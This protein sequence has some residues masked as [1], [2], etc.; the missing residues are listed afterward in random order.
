[1]FLS[2]FGLWAI[3][4]ISLSEKSQGFEDINLTTLI[5]SILQTSSKRYGKSVGILIR[6]KCFTMTGLTI[7]PLGSLYPLVAFLTRSAPY[8]FTFCP[9]SVTSLQPFAANSLI[10]CKISAN[11][12]E[13]SRP[14]VK[15]T[16]QK[17]QK[18]LQPFEIGTQA[19]STSFLKAG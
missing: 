3:T 16:T 5:L 19:F 6:P 1:M 17:V 8:E 11:G 15:G 18:L 14:R 13:T 12:L 7:R 9:K 2:I 10:S 4:S